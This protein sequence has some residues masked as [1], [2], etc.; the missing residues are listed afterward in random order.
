MRVGILNYGKAGNIFSIQKALL[1]V[2]GDV[3]VVEQDSDFKQVDKIVIPG[4]GSFGD[5]MKELS[6]FT[7]LKDEIMN[8]PTLGICLGMQLLAKVGFEFG[9]TLGLGLIDAEV[10][11]IECHGKIPHMG[12][13]NLE[14][15]KQ[16]NPLFKDIHED[17]Q[18][19]FM[20]SYEVINYSD[21]LALSNYFGHKFVSAVTKDNIF[22]VQFHP[23]K[24]RESGLLIF[25]NFIN[26]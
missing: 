24:S 18:F 1:A 11:K 2:G 9:E 7:N 20:H 14:I 17:M 5:G 23:E 25:R 3:V 16:D 22:G 13:N 19:Y 10:K 8:K 26:L 21:I 15:I 4:V 12:F 6:K